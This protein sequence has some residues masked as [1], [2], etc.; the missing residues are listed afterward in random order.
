LPKPCRPSPDLVWTQ[1]DDSDEWVVYQKASADIHLLTAS[2]HRLW[3]LAGDGLEH[4][5][6]E[7]ASALGHTQSGSDQQEVIAATRET[8]AFMDD[9]GLLL[10]LTA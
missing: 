1:F 4:S 2:A 8:L 7:L 9:A 3:T 6:E 10:P 5:V